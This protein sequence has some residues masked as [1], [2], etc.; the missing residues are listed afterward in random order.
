MAYVSSAVSRP[1]VVTVNTSQYKRLSV[2]NSRGWTFGFGLSALSTSWIVHWLPWHS[3]SDSKIQGGHFAW[4]KSCRAPSNHDM[5]FIFVQKKKMKLNVL[6]S[7]HQK[8]RYIF[9]YLE[10]TCSCRQ[11]NKLTA[12]YSCIFSVKTI[13]NMHVF[14]NFKLFYSGCWKATTQRSGAHMTRKRLHVLKAF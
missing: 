7:Q 11:L 2:L 10:L 4:A 12:C 8:G 9:F 14:Q 13:I 5:S 3:H 1:D 6:L